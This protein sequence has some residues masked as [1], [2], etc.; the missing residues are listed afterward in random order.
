MTSIQVNLNAP[1]LMTQACLPLL[2]LSQDASVVFTTDDV[3][4]EGKAFWGAYGVAK[5]GLESLCQTLAAELENSAIRTNC[6]APGPTRT[7]L[8]KRVFPG[9]DPATLK[10]PEVMAKLYLWLMG[11]DSRG[12]TGQRFRWQD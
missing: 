4:H 8:R 3:G 1:F 12:T 9:E 11:P 7:A 6:V 2:T 10:L 5:A